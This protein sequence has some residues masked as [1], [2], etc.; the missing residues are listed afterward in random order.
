LLAG[1][2]VGRGGAQRSQRAIDGLVDDVPVRRRARLQSGFGLV[3]GGLEIL[4]PGLRPDEIALV[5]QRRGIGGDRPEG[6]KIA[7]F[8]ERSPPRPAR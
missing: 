6:R 4:D 2:R 8:R 1:G 3:P 7:E 5:D